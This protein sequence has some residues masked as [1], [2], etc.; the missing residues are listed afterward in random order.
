MSKFL[1]LFGLTATDFYS[2]DELALCGND[3]KTF[4]QIKRDIDGHYH[5]T[6]G[7]DA[8]DCKGPLKQI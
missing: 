1:D 5:I 3:R 7:K 6:V 2:T 8:Q 4:G